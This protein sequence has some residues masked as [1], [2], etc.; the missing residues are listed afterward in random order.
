[1]TAGDLDGVAAATERLLASLREAPS[2]LG[3]P[4]PLPG[5]TRAHVATH[6]ARNADSFTWMLDGV[7][8]GEQREQYP[9]GATT[10][11]AAIEAGAGRPG[12]E[13][14]ADVERAAGRLAAAFA[15]M[16]GSDWAAT[17]KPSVG[18]VPAQYLVGARLREVEVHHVDLGLRYTT[19][20][21]PVEFVDRELTQRIAGLPTRLP[22]GTA[23]RLV[24]TGT[25]QSWELGGGPASVS[26]SGPG[27]AILAWL[28]GREAVGLDAPAGLPPLSPW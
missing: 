26:V 11:A 22:P 6:L 15:R 27:H 7:R 20:D 24:H 19:A 18:E 14:V 28:L 13:V 21:W 10:R 3:D 9:G 16:D 25:G 5:W 1:M 2:A 4:S 23:V 8:C 12:E 17:V